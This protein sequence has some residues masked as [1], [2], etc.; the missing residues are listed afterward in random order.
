MSSE[1]IT[2]P[3]EEY[4]ELFEDMVFLQCLY[5]LGVENWEGYEESQELF[6]SKFEE[7][8]LH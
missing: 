5:E 1:T 3:K 6:A 2:I 8:T 7:E 4:E